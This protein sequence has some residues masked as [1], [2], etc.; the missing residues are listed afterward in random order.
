[1]TTLAVVLLVLGA[2]LLVAEAHIPSFGILGS[3][4]VLALAVG[5]FLLLSGVGGGLIAAV[6]VAALTAAVAV[7]ILLLAAPHLRASRR[8]RVRV[9]RE[10]MVGHTGVVRS[11]GPPEE[12]F[13][14]G[15]LWRAQPA[16]QGEQDEQL[17]EGD[18]VVVEGVSG[19]TLSVR[20]AEDWEVQ[21]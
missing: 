1:V 9:G 16:D 10:A 12:V 13:V 4:G 5:A 19:L 7:G 6:I 20:K 18:R 17:R 2:S 14:D 21:Q 8:R 11:L 3:G 15:A